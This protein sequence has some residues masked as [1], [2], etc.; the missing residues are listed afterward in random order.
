MPSKTAKQA[1]FMRA[2]KHNRGKM[3]KKCP[4]KKVVDE[5]VTAD[6][7]KR[8]RRKRGKEKG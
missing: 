6:K 8:R 4:P 1:R 7:A 3:K 2:C 5:F